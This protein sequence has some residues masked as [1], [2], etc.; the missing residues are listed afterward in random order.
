MTHSYSRALR[1][2]AALLVAS[3]GLASLSQAQ[4]VASEGW[5]DISVE[6]WRDM[7]QGRT[8]TYNAGG[9]F[10]ANEVYH[11]STNHVMIQV[12]DGTCMEGTWS[13]ERGTYCFAWID[14]PTSC[15]RHV[16]EGGEI[17]IIPIVD[18]APAGSV[19]TVA[20]VSD[21]PLK[22]GPDLTS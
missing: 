1:T 20:G 18:G 2:A 7:V 13:Y 15:F 9:Q 19:Q 8:V 4:E 16:R 10:W 6:E 12:A 22:C 11:P 21:I 17:L 3:L 5:N 14:A